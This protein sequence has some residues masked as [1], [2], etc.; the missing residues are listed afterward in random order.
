MC[1]RGFLVIIS[2][3]ESE[4]E[5]HDVVRIRLVPARPDADGALTFVRGRKFP[6]PQDCGRLN[7]TYTPA[8]D[9]VCRTAGG[10]EC[11]SLAYRLAC[12]MEWIAMVAGSVVAVAA[13]AA[14]AALE[15]VGRPWRIRFFPRTCIRLSGVV[16]PEVVSE[17]K[18]NDV[19]NVGLAHA[20]P[21]DAPRSYR[22]TC[23]IESIAM[24]VESMVAVVAMAAVA[25]L[26]RVARPWRVW[27]AH[28]SGSSA[29]KGMQLRC[30]RQPR[31]SFGG[32]AATTAADGGLGRANS[33][34]AAEDSVRC[35]RRNGN[36]MRVTG[37][38]SPECLARPTPV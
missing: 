36:V 13:V 18:S 1:L 30:F 5:S 33:S 23:A 34:P 15:R 21:D 3:E 9:M 14:V 31:R 26:E 11:A 25:A 17:S 35:A 32:S 2:E 20:R 10:A 7:G 19:A 24:V 6:P 8:V 4:S 22:L 16:L 27:G 28:S 12:I 37:L 38:A 29:I